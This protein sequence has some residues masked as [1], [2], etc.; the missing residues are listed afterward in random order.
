LIALSNYGNND[1]KNNQHDSRDT[2]NYTQKNMGREFKD[3]KGNKY[4]ICIS[5]IIG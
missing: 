3:E 1:L 4:F 5:I 2:L